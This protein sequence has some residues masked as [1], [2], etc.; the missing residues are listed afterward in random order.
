MRGRI[1]DFSF[2][3]NRKCRITLEI[4]GDFREGYERFKN[5][6][7]DIDIKKHRKRR[8]LDANAYFHWIVNEIAKLQGLS[9]DEVKRQLVIDYGTI[10]RDEDGNT[11]GIKLSAGVDVDT[12]YPY[13]RFIKQVEEGGKLF[14]CYL[15]YKR[16]H[17]MDTAEMAHLIDGAIYEARE[18][19][20]DTDTPEQK[21]RWSSL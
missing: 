21:A 12:V 20:I 4:D 1:I 11:V 18:L 10:A 2:G 19:G 7:L 15:F 13:T 9:D 17:L 6:E 14:N 3:M 16:T 8:S 5:T